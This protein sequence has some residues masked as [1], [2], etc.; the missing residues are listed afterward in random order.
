MSLLNRLT[1]SV[2][3]L[4]AAELEDEVA[5]LPCAKLK[6]VALGDKAV[7]AGRLRSVRY[8]PTENVP[9][10]EAELYDG[11]AS[12]MLVWLGR[13]RIAG[14]EPGRRILAKGRV[15]LHDG[16]LAIYNPWYEFQCS[17]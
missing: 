17:T 8:A 7:V 12:I 2:Q 10:L 16:Q 4:D 9:L 15:G 5:Q 13:R 3:R 1:A 11:S 6:S 14:I